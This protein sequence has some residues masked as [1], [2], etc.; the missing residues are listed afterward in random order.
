MT[1][2][3]GVA[4]SFGQ[5][6]AGEQDRYILAARELVR[7]A[8]LC[9]IPVIVAP[10]PSLRGEVNGATCCVLQLNSG[11]FIV[12]ASHVLEGYEKRLQ[13]EGA[14]NWQVGALPPIDPLSSIAW[15]NVN[16]DIVFLRV[17]EEQARLACGGVARIV[18]GSTTWPPRALRIGEGIL[19]AGYVMPGLGDASNWGIADIQVATG[20]GRLQPGTLNVS[21]SAPHMLRRDF[22]LQGSQRTDGRDEDLDFERCQLVTGDGIK[23][24]AL[25]ART[26]T[27]YWKDEVLEIPLR[28]R[29]KLFDEDPVD[30]EVWVGDNAS[31]EAEEAHALG[32][33]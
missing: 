21:L 1:T 15:R 25:I 33:G 9:A 32:S 28:E 31:A 7:V 8:Q 23:V 12:T 13:N 5:L 30:V 3:S 26:S 22:Q 14:L 6:S 18:P 16:R 27:N 19:I 11:W 17:S 24:R 2:D 29:L 4:R 20:Y 10:P